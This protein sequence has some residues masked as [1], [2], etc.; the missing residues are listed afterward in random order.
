MKL[1]AL[2]N[3]KGCQGH[4]NHIMFLMIL[5][6]RKRIALQGSGCTDSMGVSYTNPKEET[7]DSIGI[8]LNVNNKYL[9]RFYGP[10]SEEPQKPLVR[11]LE[12]NLGIDIS[13]ES[14]RIR[15][16]NILQLLQD[17]HDNAFDPFL[18]IENRMEQFEFDVI[19]I[20]R[21]IEIE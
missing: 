21:S 7:R 6:S 12:K 9:K 1:S 16:A 2:N 14:E 19:D 11:I 13:F 17:A 18:K 5:E 20:L 8:I 3:L 10:I 15:F 4:N